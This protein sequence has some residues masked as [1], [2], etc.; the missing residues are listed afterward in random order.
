MSFRGDYHPAGSTAAHKRRQVAKRNGRAGGLAS[1][2]KRRQLAAGARRTRD[3][4]LGVPKAYPPVPWLSR[5]KTEALFRADC[6]RDGR[7]F[8]RGGYETVD[9]VYRVLKRWECVKGQGFEI[10]NAN[11]TAALEELG[12]GRCR[13]TV[14]YVRRRLAAMGVCRCD[15]VSRSGPRR[16][17]GRLDTIRVH[18]L[19]KRLH[20]A[21]TGQEQARRSTSG[22]LLVPHPETS[23][24]GPE[25]PDAKDCTPP[26][27]PATGESNCGLEGGKSRRSAL[28]KPTDIQED[29]A[30]E[31]LGLRRTVEFLELKI[32][33]GWESARIRSDLDAA[34]RR[35]SAAMPAGA[36]RPQQQ[37][38]SSDLCT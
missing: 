24:R 18:L 25:P 4:R 19:R 1:G 34:R 23:T 27:P 29:F 20:P 15:V 13:R 9:A 16:T 21:P 33:S 38:G 32:G 6:E 8:H 31:I 28:D 22:L 30:S 37:R 7:R 26:D 2:V 11:V 10:T 36:S 12:R 17:P 5:V 3:G 35:L 14:Q